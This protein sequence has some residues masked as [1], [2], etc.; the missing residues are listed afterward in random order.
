M[1]FERN[2]YS[3]I[4]GQT[5]VDYTESNPDGD[6]KFIIRASPQ[7]VQFIGTSQ[8]LQGPSDFQELAKVIGDASKDYLALKPKI[9]TSLSGH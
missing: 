1:K 7:G 3:H 9:V 2:K 4:S 6:L 8:P 5:V